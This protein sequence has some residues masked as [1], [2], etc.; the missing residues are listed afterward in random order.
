MFIIYDVMISR[1]HNF[2]YGTTM[3]TN[4]F[5]TSLF[6]ETVH[7]KMLQEAYA[8]TKTSGASGNAKSMLKDFTAKD[9]V[10]VTQDM[11]KSKPL[12]DL[13]PNCTVSESATKSL[14]PTPGS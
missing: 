13:F 2:L 9:G 12:A 10:A 8:E 11:F 7:R 14:L 4:E 6:P 1:R 5:V 3:R